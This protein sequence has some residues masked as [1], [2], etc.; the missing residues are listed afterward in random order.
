MKELTR[1]DDIDLA[2]LDRVVGC[3][4]RKCP[5]GQSGLSWHLDPGTDRTQFPTV[6]LLLEHGADR[7]K[8]DVRGRTPLERA[9]EQDKKGAMGVLQSE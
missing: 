1:N 3:P 9:R 8:R 2:H 6:G 4:D 5:P 7:E